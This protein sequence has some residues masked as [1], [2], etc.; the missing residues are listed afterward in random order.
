MPPHILLPST[1]KFNE[2]AGIRIIFFC[3]LSDY[4][5]YHFTVTEKFQNYSSATRFEDVAPAPQS[6][7]LSDFSN[8]DVYA[9]NIIILLTL[10]PWLVLLVVWILMF[11]YFI[12]IICFISILHVNEAGGCYIFTE[13]FLCTSTTIMAVSRY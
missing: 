5:I 12:C 7:P 8:S 4:H 6:V 13:F 1:P 11:F 2:A 9:H 3:R 10:K